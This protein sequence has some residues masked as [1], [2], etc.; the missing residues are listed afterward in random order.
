MQQDNINQS[1]NDIDDK[2]MGKRFCDWPT[3]TVASISSEPVP[4]SAGSSSLCLPID[5][6]GQYSATSYPNYSTSY[7]G[8]NPYWF[9]QGAFNSNVK[10]GK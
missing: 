7:N 6:S 3:M 9:Y 10:P 5:S 2:N 8:I 1:N 4:I